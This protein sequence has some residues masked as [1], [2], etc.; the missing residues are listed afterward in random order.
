MTI[1][2]QPFAVEVTAGP[3]GWVVR[4]AGELDLATVPDLDACLVALDS[5]VVVDLAGMTFIDSRGTA[6]LIRGHQGAVKR[7]RSFVLRSP[8]DRVLHVLRLT[9]LDRVFTIEP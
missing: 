4:V 5:D 2:S 9:G 1:A 8:T 7:G 3:A 6:A